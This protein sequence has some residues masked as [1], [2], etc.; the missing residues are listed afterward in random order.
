MGI[1]VYDGSEFTI[2]DRV[3]AHVQLAVS[4]KLRRGESFLLNWNTNPDNGSSRVSLWLSP[5]VPLQFHF[6]GSR[7]PQLNRAWLDVLTEL[8]FTARG[9]LIVSEA[10]AEA[11]KAGTLALDDVHP[12]VI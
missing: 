11:V 5:A 10:D 9:M 8:A 12:M 2:D 3:L 1:L 7:Q 6:Y 4:I